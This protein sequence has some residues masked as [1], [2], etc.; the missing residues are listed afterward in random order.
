MKVLFLTEGGRNSGFG[1]ITRCVALSQGFES[2]GIY[3]E[4]IINGDDYITSLLEDKKYTLFNWVEEKDK[5]FE[6]AKAFD[7]VVIDSYLAGKDIYCKLSELFKGRIVMIDDYQRLDYPKGFVV[8]PSICAES[9]NYPDIEGVKYL[10]GRD[11]IILRK[12]FWKVS[13][14][15]ISKEIK[16]V[17]ITFGGSDTSA[18]LESIAGKLKKAFDAEF[19]IIDP[20][21]DR[22]KAEDMLNMMLECD[23]CISGGGQTLYELI[24]IGVPTIGICIV[25]NQRRNLECC[26]KKGLINYVGWYNDKKISNR[27]KYLIKNKFSYAE[28]LKRFR[29]GKEGV[30]GRGIDRIVK[31]L[32][33]KIRKC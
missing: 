1:H 24:R 7:A 3:T 5:L 23:I 12:E 10:L 11:Y 33:E 22:L 2:V 4:F 8:N 13:E 28:R 29:A 20:V 21:K 16:K 26:G 30:D 19:I 6:I 17:L 27:I 32:L 31:N 18:V 15:R 25:G 14:K 9:L